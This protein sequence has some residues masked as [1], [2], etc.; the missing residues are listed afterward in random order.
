MSELD[1]TRQS[2]LGFAFRELRRLHC[3]AC[4]CGEDGGGRAALELG[5]EGREELVECGLDIFEFFLVFL[6]LDIICL[7]F[8]GFF[9]EDRGRDGEK[10]GVGREGFV[11]CCEEW[12]GFV[13]S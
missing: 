1:G 10:G 12:A 6:G 3:S 5:L 7:V 9:F 8:V 4:H 13:I 11:C 2:I